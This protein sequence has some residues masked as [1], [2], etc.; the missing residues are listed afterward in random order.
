MY[1]GKCRGKKV[2]LPELSQSTKSDNAERLD[3]REKAKS[4]KTQV[5]MF[6]LELTLSTETERGR[7]LEKRI[8][9]M[10]D[11]IS[12]KYSSQT[13][14]ENKKEPYPPCTHSGKI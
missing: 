5:S 2:H 6:A 3:E 13:F 11:V 9:A 14:L 10:P 8:L 12:V 4:D 1:S 7:P